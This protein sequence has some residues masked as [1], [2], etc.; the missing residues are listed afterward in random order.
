MCTIDTSD[1]FLFI[2][3]IHQLLGCEVW[4]LKSCQDFWMELLVWDFST[5]W[6]WY[7]GVRRFLFV[8]VSFYLFLSPFPFSSKW[9]FLTDELLSASCRQSVKYPWTHLKKITAQLDFLRQRVSECSGKRQSSWDCSFKHS[10]DANSCRIFLIS[11][12]VD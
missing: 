6:I 12:Q 8:V 9:G 1:S 7:Q 2:A 4:C 10:A 5:L 11:K 3:H